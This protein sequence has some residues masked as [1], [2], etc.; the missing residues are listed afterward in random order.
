MKEE[1]LLRAQHIGDVIDILQTT[2]RHLYDPDEL[3]TVRFY[4]PKKLETFRNVR[5][6]SWPFCTFWQ[7]TRV[8]NNSSKILWSF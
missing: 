7:L 5:K 1:D 2:S 8:G 3:L 4:F 6:K